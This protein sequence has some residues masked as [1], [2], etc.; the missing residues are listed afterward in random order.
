VNNRD[1]YRHPHLPPGQR[2]AYRDGF[3]RGYQAAMNH[4]MGGPR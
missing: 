4:L 2:E 1:E 3:R